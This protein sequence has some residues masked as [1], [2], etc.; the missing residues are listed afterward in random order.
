MPKPEPKIV[1]LSSGIRV[2]VRQPSGRAAVHLARIVMQPTPED[3]DGYMA[4]VAEVLHAA[5]GYLDVEVDKEAVKAE[6]ELW[7]AEGHTPPKG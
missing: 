6:R 3:A 1:E 5:S 4:R 2:A 7:L